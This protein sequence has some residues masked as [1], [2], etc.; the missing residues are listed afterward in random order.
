MPRSCRFLP[1]L[2]LLVAPGCGDDG[3]PVIDAAP[4]PDVARIDAGPVMGTLTVDGTFVVENPD[5]LPGGAN[6][7]VNCEL[8]VSRDGVPVT[9]AIITVNPAIPAFQTVLVGEALDPSR[10]VGNYTGYYETA[11]VTI[12]TENET[13]GEILV[14]GPKMFV[15]EQPAREATV[16]AGADLH[17]TWSQPE[18]AVDAATVAT[19]NLAEV[20]MADTGVYD[21]PGMYIDVAD[22]AV[23][24]TRWND[25]NLAPGAA[26]GSEIRFGVHSVQPFHLP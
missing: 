16:T 25:N 21:V 7:R 24:I 5:N 23:E 22:D 9:D 6:L 17:V 14:Q 3:D 13:T 20:M 15:I 2:L 4:P 11:K 8:R 10:Y 1:V 12:R 19:T 18:G 26:P